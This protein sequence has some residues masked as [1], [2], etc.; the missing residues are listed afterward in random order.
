MS[1][2]YEFKII[3]K[4][5]RIDV[6]IFGFSVLSELNFIRLAKIYFFLSA[7]IFIY[8]DIIILPEYKITINYY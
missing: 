1:S 4:F 2:S 6:N 5:L 3:D 8:E 7:F